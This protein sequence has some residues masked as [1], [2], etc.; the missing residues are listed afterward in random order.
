MPTLTSQPSRGNIQRS[1]PPNI[2]NK[3]E[4]NST[5][6][7][8]SRT[9]PVRVG[10]V[11]KGEP[12]QNEVGEVLTVIHWDRLSEIRHARM[13]AEVRGLYATGAIASQLIVPIGGSVPWTESERA[14]YAEAVVDRNVAGISVMDSAI[15]RAAERTMSI[16]LQV[17]IANQEKR[18]EP[19]SR[20]WR[21]AQ[22]RGGRK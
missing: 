12:I 21:T 18:A 13:I 2:V 6:R 4:S 16:I 7:G 17:S 15:S 11:G 20:A 14:S 22:K 10:Y 3:L 8:K 1:E 19:K 9:S 5:N